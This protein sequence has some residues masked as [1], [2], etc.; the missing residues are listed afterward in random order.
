MGKFIETTPDEDTV[1]D[2]IERIKGRKVGSRRVET[3]YR[4]LKSYLENK[5]TIEEA[6]EIQ[7]RGSQLPVDVT[8]ECF[9]LH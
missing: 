6:N 7:D 5:V 9:Y 4:L 3:I 1:R 2:R 8:E